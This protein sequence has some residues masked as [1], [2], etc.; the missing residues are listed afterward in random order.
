VL[1]FVGVNKLEF[2]LK[3][4][5]ITAGAAKLVLFVVNHLK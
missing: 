1:L 2:V 4:G 3:L 5:G